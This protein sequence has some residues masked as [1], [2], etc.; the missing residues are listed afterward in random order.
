MPWPMA[1]KIASAAVPA[2]LAAAGG[3]ALV[4]HQTG[5][6]EQPRQAVSATATE[7]TACYEELDALAAKVARS[8]RGIDRLSAGRNGKEETCS[9]KC[10]V[11]P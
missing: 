2:L 3:G 4:G 9:A 11:L 8:E 1:A 7:L 5:K 10:L 6:P